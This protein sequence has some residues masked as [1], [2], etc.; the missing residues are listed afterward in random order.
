MARVNSLLPDSSFGSS[1][2]SSKSEV[3]SSSSDSDLLLLLRDFFLLSAVS[4]SSSAGL[5]LETTLGFC[6]WWHY[7]YCANN[8]CG[9]GNERW[10]K[11]KK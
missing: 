4:K 6:V 1:M 7:L 2:M 5:R 8:E 10:H 3:G 11:T 9:E